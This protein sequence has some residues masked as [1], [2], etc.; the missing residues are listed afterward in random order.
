MIQSSGGGKKLML[1]GGKWV[2][3]KGYWYPHF[4]HGNVMGGHKN[5]VLKTPGQQQGW[6][7]T[8][9]GDSAYGSK[10]L[11]SKQVQNALNTS[12]K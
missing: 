5:W 4:G 6:K 3:S 11:T 8:Q 10:Y 7:Y 12:I 9:G 2:S 1:R